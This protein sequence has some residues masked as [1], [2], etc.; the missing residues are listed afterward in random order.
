MRLWPGHGDFH[1]LVEW[2]KTDSFSTFLKETCDQMKL[3]KD[4]EWLVEV[5]RDTAERMPNSI[6]E[7]QNSEYLA[8]YILSLD[9][10]RGSLAIIDY[11][12]R[13]L[14]NM[15]LITDQVADSVEVQRAELDDLLASLTLSLRSRLGE[16]WGYSNN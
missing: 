10:V 16:Q 2:Q 12:V 7:G 11:C 5:L 1:T 15:D 3:A 4:R 6:A 8:E 9:S 13:F 14:R